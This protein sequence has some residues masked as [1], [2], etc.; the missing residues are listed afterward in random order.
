MTRLSVCLLALVLS[1]GRTAAQVPGLPAPPTSPQ[2]P[3]QLPRAGPTEP[4]RSLV[5][6]LVSTR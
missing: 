6:R 2:L 3:G 5:W 4:S 1:A